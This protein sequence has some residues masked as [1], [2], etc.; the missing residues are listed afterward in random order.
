[1]EKGDQLVR[2]I[3][4]L[5]GEDLPQKVGVQ[6]Q[7]RGKEEKGEGDVPGEGGGLLQKEEEEGDQSACGEADHG[8]EERPLEDAEEEDTLLRKL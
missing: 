3:R 8:G 4:R 5:P 2:G 1:M 6:G 7:R